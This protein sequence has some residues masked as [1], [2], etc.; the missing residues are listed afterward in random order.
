MSIQ[1][2]LVISTRFSEQDSLDSQTMLSHLN[3]VSNQ[4]VISFEHINCAENPNSKTTAILNQALKNTNHDVIIFLDASKT[5]RSDLISDLVEK[6]H[7]A[8]IVTIS[9]VDSSNLGFDLVKYWSK[10][11]FYQ[12]I[13][14]CVKR[15]ELD[16]HKYPDNYYFD[17]TFYDYYFSDLILRLCTSNYIN[18]KED[19]AT[20]PIS[21]LEEK[22]RLF[23]KFEKINCG[24]ESRFA[25]VVP[26]RS[27]GSD[28]EQFIASVE[29]QNFPDLEVIVVGMQVDAR[30]T[31]KQLRA[32]E[33]KLRKT[34]IRFVKS[35]STTQ[36]G[37]FIDGGLIARSEYLFLA[38]ATS[39]LQPDFVTSEIRN[40]QK[41]N[42]AAVN[43]PNQQMILR[44]IAFDECISLGGNKF[45]LKQMFD[46]FDNN[47]WSVVGGYSHVE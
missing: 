12:L 13:A 41:D 23:R 31:Q 42:V 27:Y 22:Q 32:L 28:L 38:N 17:E 29:Q 33:D 24:Y 2:I 1:K 10:D 47:Q 11:S 14:L 6:L 26:I 46:S 20:K 43:L 36:F 30:M 44:K 34:S 5:Y 45:N 35:D 37:A 3:S 25:F 40:F 9:N 19:F 4:S 39:F 7:T 16:R 8:A 15:S 21:N 18:L